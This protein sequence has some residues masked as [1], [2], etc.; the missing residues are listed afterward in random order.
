VSDSQKARVSDERRYGGAIGS[1]VAGTQAKTIADAVGRIQGRTIIDVGTGTGRSALLLARGGA[2]V[3]G[4]DPSE[5][6]LQTA[7]QRAAKESLAVTFQ[8]GEVYKLDFPDKS[9]EVALCLRVLMHTPEWRE[10]VLEMCRV[11]QQLVILDYSSRRS[12][13]AIQVPIRRVLELVGVPKSGYQLHSDAEVRDALVAGGFRVRATHRLFVL[14]MAF[15]RLI[16][17]RRLTISIEHVLGRLGLRTLFGSP[18]TLV[19]ERLPSSR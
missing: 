19:A 17:S 2:K 1:V 15:H 6:L 14:P 8:E 10:C 16:G 11:T 7:R 13:A 3:T 9:F 5:Q 4:I 12:L 18:V